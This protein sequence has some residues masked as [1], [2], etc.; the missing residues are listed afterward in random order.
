MKALKR[1][2][3]TFR[4]FL[5][6]AMAFLVATSSLATAFASYGSL[7]AEPPEQQTVTVEHIWVDNGI[8]VVKQVEE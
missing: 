2:K 6:F 8:C 1:M 5:V 3:K 4:S 7:F